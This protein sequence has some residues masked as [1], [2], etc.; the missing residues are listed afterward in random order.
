MLFPAIVVCDSDVDDAN[1]CK[2]LKDEGRKVFRIQVIDARVDF[3]TLCR[4]SIKHN[5]PYKVVTVREENAQE[6]NTESGQASKKLHT[7]VEKE[8]RNI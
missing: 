5:I 1:V 6:V 8:R 3:V 7:K 2:G 4:K